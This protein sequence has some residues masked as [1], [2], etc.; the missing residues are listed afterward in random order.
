MKFVGCLPRSGYLVG[1]EAMSTVMHANLMGIF[2]FNAEAMASVFYMVCLD[3]SN[4]LEI[5]SGVF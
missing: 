3:E 5:S 1:S 2:F 4:G